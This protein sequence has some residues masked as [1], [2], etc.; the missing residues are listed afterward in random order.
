MSNIRLGRLT[1]YDCDRQTDRQ[2]NRNN[3]YRI[4]T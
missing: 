1:A 2:T 4:C 3:I